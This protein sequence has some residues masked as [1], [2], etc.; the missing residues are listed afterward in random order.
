MKHTTRNTL[1]GLIGLTTLA[2]NLCPLTAPAAEIRKANNGDPLEFGS[3]WI[4]G[5][6]PTAADVAVWDDAAGSYSF[7]TIQT[8]TSWEGIAIRDMLDQQPT[9]EFYIQGIWPNTFN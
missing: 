5:M 1:A 8:N 6:A 2:L 9:I 3:S 4:G 7:N